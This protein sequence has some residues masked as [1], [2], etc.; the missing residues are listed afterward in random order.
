[1]P[2][3]VLPHRPQVDNVPAC[4]RLPLLRHHLAKL[5][6]TAE[7]LEIELPAAREAIDLAL[8]EARAG[9]SSVPCARCAEAAND[10]P[11]GP[12][13]ALVAGG[14]PS[15]DARRVDVLG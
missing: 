5:E 15:S 4:D 2:L 9:A 6:A 3:S 7:D 8:R 12:P 10:P 13:S 1:M 11:E 14:A